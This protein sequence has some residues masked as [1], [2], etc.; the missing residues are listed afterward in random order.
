MEHPNKHGSPFAQDRDLDFER[1]LAAVLVADTQPARKAARLAARRARRHLRQM[2][3]LG[4][5]RYAG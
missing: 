4:L 5:V 2:Q 3:R 1:W